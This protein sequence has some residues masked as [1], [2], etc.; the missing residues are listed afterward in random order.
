VT[1]VTHRRGDLVNWIELIRQFVS[2][3]L[4]VFAYASNHTRELARQ[5]SSYFEDCAGHKIE[6]S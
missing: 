3:S 4:K 6:P 1:T 5:W 2:R